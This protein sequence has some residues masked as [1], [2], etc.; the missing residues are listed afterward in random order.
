MVLRN[1]LF[2]I[3]L[4]VAGTS[5]AQQNNKF[6]GASAAAMGGSS[7]ALNNFWGCNNNQA[8]LGFSDNFGVGIFSENRFLLKS[9]MHSHI[10]LAMPIKNNGAFGLNIDYF[11]DKLFNQKIIGIA[12]GRS[13]GKRF[14]FGLQLDYLNTAIGN[15]YGNKSNITFEAGILAKLSSELFLGAHVF[16]P[17]QSKLQSD[18]DQRIQSNLRIGLSWLPSD[19]IIATA[20]VESDILNK[21]IYKA[22]LEYA[23]T[24]GIFGRI[25]YSNNPNIFS[26]GV[27][28]VLGDFTLD[29]SSSM[30]TVLGYSPQF[31]ICYIPKKK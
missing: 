13:L 18:A 7:V 12:Y 15:N 6:A 8:T 22:G 10:S 25:G 29:F 24:K 11:G 2:L 19:K 1:L 30:H 21:P 3:M 20:E 26:F 4:F 27:G 9:M 16:N 23:I 17:I 14:S 31:S 28:V 5:L